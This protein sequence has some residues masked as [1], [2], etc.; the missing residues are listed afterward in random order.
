MESLDKDSTIPIFLDE[1]NE[2]EKESENTDEYEKRMKKISRRNYIKILSLSLYSIVYGYQIVIMN[3]MGDPLL[4]D[5]YKKDDKE[6]KV[7]L[8][9]IN[10]MFPLGSLLSVLT[11]G[12]ISDKIGRMKL[13]LVFDVMNIFIIGMYW[14]QNL[15]VLQA[16]RFLSGWTNAGLNMICTIMITESM[17]PHMRGIGNSVL[18]AFLTSSVF[19]GLMIPS[20]L[21]RQ[22]IVENWRYIMCWMI[23]PAVFKTIST[24]VVFKYDSP[25]HFL[26]MNYGKNPSLREGLVEIYRDSYRESKV[27]E[28]VDMSI[29]L[30]EEKESVSKTTLLSGF[31]DMVSKNYRYSSFIGIYVMVASQLTGI[32]YINAYSTDIFNRISGKGK[33]ATKALA[34]S[35]SIGGILSLYLMK[36]FGRKF[37]LMLSTFVQ[38]L[39][40]TVI[41]LSIEYKVQELAYLGVSVYAFGFALGMGPCSV[42]YVTEVQSASATSISVAMSYLVSSIMGKVLPLIAVDYGDKV[43]IISFAI[44]SLLVLIIFDMILIETRNKSEADIRRDLLSKYKYRPLYFK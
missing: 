27:N 21:T 35:K 43:I 26:R 39:G 10:M 31:R 23:I 42:A 32:F 30:H 15:W 24:F 14:I 8:G 19:M 1:S 29:K 4:R 5:V 13:I 34:F 28:V 44:S 16:V 37:N 7:I 40:L 36:N 17:P 41:Y 3:P 33:E 9:T 25:K 6:V 2:R 18:Y 11:S 38:F 20:M 22:Q 12:T